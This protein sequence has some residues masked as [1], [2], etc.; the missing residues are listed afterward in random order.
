ETRNDC[1]R[2]LLGAGDP[3]TLPPVRNRTLSWRP[4]SGEPAGSV[5]TWE[6]SSPL[7]FPSLSTGHFSHVD[8]LD[9]LQR[10]Q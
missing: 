8:P 9:G 4:V 6:N 7:S 10:T 2:E 1:T 3:A 5:R